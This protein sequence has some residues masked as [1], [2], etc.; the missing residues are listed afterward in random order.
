M[1]NITNPISF[2]ID[3]NTSL[4]VSCQLTP[5]WW[6]V[7]LQRELINVPNTKHTSKLPCILLGV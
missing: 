5:A 3:I 1:N 6:T 4:G 2:Q 7:R